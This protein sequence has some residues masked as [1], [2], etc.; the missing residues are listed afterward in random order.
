MIKHWFVVICVLVAVMLPFRTTNAQGSGDLVLGQ[1]V[2]GTITTPGETFSLTYQLAEPRAVTFQA[3]A[4]SAQPMMTVLRDGKPVAQQ[5][6]PDNVS[7]IS[8]VAYLPAGNYVVQIGTINNTTGNVV[9]VVQAETVLNPIALVA[10]STVTG[11][12]TTDAPLALYS[13]SSLL[14]PAYL[15][16]DSSLPDQGIQARLINTVTGNVSATVYQDMLGAR[17]RIP[18]GIQAYQLEITQGEFTLCFVAASVGNCGDAPGG[19]PA[20]TVVNQTAAACTVTPQ[21]AGGAN[22]RQSADVNAPALVAL[23]GGTS[24]DVLG[25]SPDGA[26]Y[27][28]RYNNVTGWAALSAVTASGSCSN[29]S[30]VN[31]PPVP[32]TSTPIPPTATPLPTATATPAGPCVIHFSAPEYIYTLPNT[33]P[34]NIYHQVSAGDEAIVT[35][36]WTGDGDWWKTNYGNAWWLNAPGTAGQLMGN[37][38]GIP[39]ITP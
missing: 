29:L 28:V 27:N 14:E 17:L 35:G 30:V 39:M 13:F 37:C 10:G 5:T 38:S 11:S 20:P 7:T 26:W 6:N 25:I 12:V 23:L 8:L 36:H 15:Y 34:G 19:T 16:L 9:V 21:F 4:E 2:T 32:P 18:G 31:P 3:L 33:D 1:P 24:A 22:I